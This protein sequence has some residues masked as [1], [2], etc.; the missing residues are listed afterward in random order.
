MHWVQLQSKLIKQICRPFSTCCGL[1]WAKYF[2]Y[3]CSL[4][5]FS[6]KEG[7]ELAKQIEEIIPEYDIF[8]SL[9]VI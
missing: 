3:I 7:D 9:C 6:P 2:F 4:L 8:E 1:A 5:S